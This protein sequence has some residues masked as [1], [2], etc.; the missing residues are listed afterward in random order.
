[1]SAPQQPPRAWA[2]YDG[3]GEY[4]ATLIADP[5]TRDRNVPA[6]AWVFADVFRPDRKRVRLSDGVLEDLPEVS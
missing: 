4:V 2:I 5:A 6:G 1:M 3:A